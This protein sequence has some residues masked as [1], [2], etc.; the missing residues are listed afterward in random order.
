MKTPEELRAYVEKVIAKKDPTWQECI[1][2]I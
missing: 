1:F 2:Q